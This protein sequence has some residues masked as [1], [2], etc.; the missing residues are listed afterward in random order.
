MRFL[1]VLV[2]FSIP[3]VYASFGNSGL[4]YL[5]N[6]RHI[7]GL[8]AQNANPSDLLKRAEL[9]PTDQVDDGIGLVSS[10]S[11]VYVPDPMDALNSSSDSIVFSNAQLTEDDP[12]EESMQNLAAQ[13]DSNAARILTGTTNAKNPP[14]IIEE[15][16][17][18]RAGGV[19]P[20]MLGRAKV[21]KDKSLAIF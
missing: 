16:L 5:I 7:E 2:L 12:L 9:S 20:I 1:I 18:Q 14:E 3:L 6:Q 11:A 17:A 15:E 19:N 4:A 21:T 10:S 8:R 13:E